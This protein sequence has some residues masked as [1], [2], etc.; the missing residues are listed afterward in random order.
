MVDPFPGGVVQLDGDV[1]VHD[2]CKD[3]HVPV[4]RVTYFDEWL[5]VVPE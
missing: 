3:S 4:G 2:C 5:E 1:R